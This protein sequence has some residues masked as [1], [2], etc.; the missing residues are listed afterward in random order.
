MAVNTFFASMPPEAFLGVFLGLKQSLKPNTRMH[1]PKRKEDTKEGARNLFY[2][3]PL[4]EASPRF[5]KLNVHPS[6]WR[7]VEIL[8]NELNRRERD[9]EIL[10][11]DLEYNRIMHLQEHVA[12]EIL[13]SG[14]KSRDRHPHDLGYPP[15]N[16]V[17]H[18]FVG[19][20]DP[21]V[22]VKVACSACP[23][24]DVPIGFGEILALPHKPTKTRVKR[25][26]LL[27][28]FPRHGWVDSQVFSQL[29]VPDTIYYLP[30]DTTGRLC[31]HG[32]P[33][34]Y[35]IY[36]LGCIVRRPVISRYTPQREHGVGGHVSPF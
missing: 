2:G 30:F 7:E 22:D 13:N 9:F 25:M 14:E 28:V 6:P 3:F 19:V 26:I 17:G 27:Q 35:R 11:G 10:V 23:H 18:G 4:T 32:L 36:R 21:R 16:K 31:L 15:L 29:A 33:R 20:R 12:T 8:H 24:L 34:A 5:T 1:A